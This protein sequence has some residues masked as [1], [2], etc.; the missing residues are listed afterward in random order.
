MVDDVLVHVRAELVLVV[1]EVRQALRLGLGVRHAQVLLEET[2]SPEQRVALEGRGP[3][4]QMIRVE[5]AGG[6][7]PS[8]SGMGHLEVSTVLAGGEEQHVVQRVERAVALIDAL[9]TTRPRPNIDVSPA[10][11]PAPVVE[12]HAHFLQTFRSVVPPR[13]LAGG[14]RLR[15]HHERAVPHFVRLQSPPAT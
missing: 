15:V 2:A 9:Y 11:L 13:V 7:L 1:A 10:G 5:L 14:A 12:K 4:V 6:H 3:L 8:P